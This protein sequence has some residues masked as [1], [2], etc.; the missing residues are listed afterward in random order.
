MSPN[1]PD[2]HKYSPP[3]HCNVQAVTIPS[4]M[5]AFCRMPLGYGPFPGPRQT[6]SG[7]PHH[8]WNEARSTTYSLIFKADKSHLS[9]FLP[10][11]HFRI[12]TE[13]GLAYASFALVHL[14]NLPWLAGRGYNHFGFYIHDVVCKDGADEV[15]GKY[16]I[17]LFEDCA[18]AI[19]SGREELG[20]AKLWADLS[21][22]YESTNMRLCLGW[23][24]SVFGELSINGLRNNEG[25]V[26]DPAKVSFRPMQGIL[27]YKYV[28]RTGSPGEADVQ[29]PTFT[30][31]P[32]EGTSRVLRTALSQTGHFGFKALSF[33][34]LPTLHH[35]AA[36]L[37]ELRPQGPV[38]CI[39]IEE[40][41]VSDISSQR[42]LRA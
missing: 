22:K 29:Y 39:V 18:D 37:S 35:V 21:A 33:A 34:E 23:D 32:A 38:D 9:T 42:I 2:V 28:P 8:G 26:P 6:T 31:A 25:D 24:G 41:G 40:V 14:E 30:P 5:S 15:R 16:L 20:Y 1:I 3:G 11:E 19:T 17:V 7:L 36:R 27:H 13:N 4:E 12:D 10:N